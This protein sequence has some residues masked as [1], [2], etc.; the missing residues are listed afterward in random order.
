MKILKSKISNQ[1]FTL[2][3]IMIVVIILGVIAAFALPSYN[4][5]V[6]KNDILTARTSMAQINTALQGYLLN[7]DDFSSKSR[8]TVFDNASK[9]LDLVAKKKYSYSSIT[10]GKDK[11]KEISPFYFLLAEP[12]NGKLPFIWMSSGGDAYRCSDLASAKARKKT[13]K[14]QKL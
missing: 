12:D 3:E 9:Q 7:N 4:R 11:D 1:G 8:Q 5:Y 14:C 2:V 10:L 13:D 6:E